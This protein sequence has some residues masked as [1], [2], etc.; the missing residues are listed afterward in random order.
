MTAMES[1]VLSPLSW[2]VEG[3]PPPP[4]PAAMD[5]PWLHASRGEAPGRTNLQ[6]VSA[7]DPTVTRPLSPGST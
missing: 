1:A 7:G 3:T 6:L 5:K 2:A 4:L